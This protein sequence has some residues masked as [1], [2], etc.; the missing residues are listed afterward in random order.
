MRTLPSPSED[1]RL[2]NTTGIL[3]SPSNGLLV[4]CKV[5]RYDYVFSAVYIML[6]PSRKPS[7]SLLKFVYVT[8]YAV[9]LRGAPLLRIILDPHL[10]FDN[11]ARN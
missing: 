10:S 4:F 1:L 8:S 2:S 7:Y 5:C 9:L 3:R 6:L 11:S